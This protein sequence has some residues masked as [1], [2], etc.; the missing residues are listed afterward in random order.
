MGL[1]G[2]LLYSVR[3]IRFALAVE[4]C[5]LLG[6][7]VAARGW[8]QACRRQQK[9]WFWPRSIFVGYMAALL[10]ITVVRSGID[11]QNIWQLHDAGTVQLIPLYYTWQQ[12]D[13]GWWNFIYP[14]CGN[15][16]WF[17]PFGFLLPC[18]GSGLKRWQAV[19]VCGLLL[20]FGI[21]CLQWIF[22]SG[23]SDIDD[24][25]FNGM[26]ALLGYWIGAACRKNSKNF[27]V[28]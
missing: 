28:L 5:W 13:V 6:Y 21:E 8:S 16:L 9:R 20:S 24:I 22:G 17:V 14:V 2:I 18:L 27:F 12:L 26:G 15:I 10:Q 23:V 3:A 1:E 25:I 4:L 11:W 7:A 19:L